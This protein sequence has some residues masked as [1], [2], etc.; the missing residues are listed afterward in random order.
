MREAKGRLSD[1]FE[2]A[3][4]RVAFLVRFCTLYLPLTCRTLGNCVTSWV[5]M[6]ILQPSLPALSVGTRI[7]QNLLDLYG[8]WTNLHRENSDV[9]I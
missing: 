5:H 7:T 4:L 2:L 1:A 8:E 3:Y 9:L 6:L